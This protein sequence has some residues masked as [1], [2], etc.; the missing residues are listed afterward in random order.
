MTGPGPSS[1]LEFAETTEDVARLVLSTGVAH[2]CAAGWARID[3]PQTKSSVGGAFV[4]GEGAPLAVPEP[5]RMLFDLAS[6]T[7]PMLAVAIARAPMDRMRALH[8]LLP[9]VKGTL[10][11][12]T[13]LD[14][15]LSHR[16]GLE[17]N[18]PL[19]R[20]LLDE[21]ASVRATLL[22]EAAGARRPECVGAPPADGF[23]PVYSDLGYVLA[24]EALARAQRVV[25]AGAAIGDLVVAPLGLGATLGTARNLEATGVDV[26]RLAAPTERVPWRGGVVRGLVHDENAWMLT[27]KGGS[28]HAGM[29]GTAEAVLAFGVYVLRNLEALEWTWRPRPGGSLRA[30]FDGKSEEGSSA[31]RR[32]GARA[33]GHLGFTGTSLWIDPDAGVV[34]TLLTNRVYPTRDAAAIRAARPAAHDALVKM[35]VSARD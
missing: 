9:E 29:F 23:A 15:L 5:A 33:F 27:A 16:A 4:A 26:A 8:E 20:R 18:L 17:A 3:G 35:A 19:Y 34:V 32:M 2:A 28:G 22:R 6:V 30:G 7:K 31:G 14:A 21:G 1:N 24:G 25:D 12:D 11:A 10:S 13:T